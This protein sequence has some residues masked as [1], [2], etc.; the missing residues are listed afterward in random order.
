MVT[1]TERKPDY[2]SPWKEVLELYFQQFS[3]FFF[4]KIHSEID[5][6]KGYQLLDKELQKV[7][8]EAKTGRRLI[9]KLVKVWRKDG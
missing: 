8:R 7:V 1:K 3:A 5:W 2:D 9:D 6:S 4:P